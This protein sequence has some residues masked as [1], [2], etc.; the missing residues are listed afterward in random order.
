MAG[1]TL[2]G[3]G[4]NPCKELRGYQ[5]SPARGLGWRQ[6]AVAF[7]ETLLSYRD[8]E[9]WN[10]VS[11]ATGKECSVPSSHVAKVWHR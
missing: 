6:V 1:C 5:P 9:W 11:L 8:G 10:V 4:V 7:L 3:E 2:E